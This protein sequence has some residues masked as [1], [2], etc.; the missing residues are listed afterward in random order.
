MKKKEKLEKVRY[1]KKTLKVLAETIENHNIL[2]SYH[3]LNQ[4]PENKLKSFLDY[5]KE[6]D[7]KNDLLITIKKSENSEEPSLA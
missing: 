6:Y 3:L 5:L 4:M 1:D 2:D 7:T